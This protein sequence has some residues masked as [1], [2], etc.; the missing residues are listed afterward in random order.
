MNIFQRSAQQLCILAG[1]F[2]GVAIILAIS[3]A[4]GRGRISTVA[5]LL[6]GSVFSTL[7]NELGQLVQYYVST[8][9]DETTASAINTLIG[10]S[11]IGE[12]FAWSELLLMAAP[13]LVCSIVIFALAG[14]INIIVFG[15]AEARAMGINV[16]RYRNA[17][18]VLCTILSAVVLAFCGTVSMV[19]FLV[20]HFARYL[21]G[22]DFKK[23]VPASAF[24]GGITTLLVY[25][26]CYM[27][28]QL[29]RF[30]MYTGVVCS[31]L[32]AFFIIFY[33]RNRHA[34]WS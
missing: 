20:P 4:A 17:L 32:S 22:P 11:Y 1:C 14:K 31:I 16:T 30:N 12:T 33:R 23:L 10:G 8:Y 25:D 29:S 3:M 7:I 6:A 27:T 2:L 19:G 24:L 9:G 18:I 5:L 21:V 26:V 15:E 34:D 13:I 28:A